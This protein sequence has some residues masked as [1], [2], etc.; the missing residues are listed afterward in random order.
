[1]INAVLNLGTFW[2]N[3]IYELSDVFDLPDEITTDN[4]QIVDKREPL[5]ILQLKR[6]AYACRYGDLFQRFGRA[7]PELCNITKTVK[8]MIYTYHGH[9]LTNLNQP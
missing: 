3:D 1:M 8:D 4:R 9:F 7:V 5:C 6:F 2:K